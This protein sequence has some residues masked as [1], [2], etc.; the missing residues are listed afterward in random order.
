LQEHRNERRRE[1][2]RGGRVS[3]VAKGRRREETHS[4]VLPRNDVLDR[5]LEILHRVRRPLDEERQQLS[6]YLYSGDAF[7]RLGGEGGER[8]EGECTEGEGVGETAQRKKIRT[9]G[10][11]KERKMRTGQPRH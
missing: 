11:E 3:G 6:Q 5:L 10:N 9:R 4:R 2:L 7:G 8:G 1:A